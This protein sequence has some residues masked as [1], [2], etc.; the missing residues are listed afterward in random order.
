MGIGSKVVSTQEIQKKL[1]SILIYFDTFCKEHHLP[2]V[3]AGGT[4]L[5]AVRH[6]GFIP[7]DDD[8]DVFMLRKDYEKLSDIW[9]KY[10]DTSRY[11][12]V[13]S[14]EKLNIHHTA[15]EVKD[16]HTTF[17]NRHSIDV[18]MHH[19]L[20]IDII[21][22]DNVAKSILAF[23][24]QV[25][26]ALQYAGFNFQRLPDHKSK[27]VYYLT[28]VALTVIKSPKARYKLW[29]SAEQIIISLG[30]NNSGKV[31]SFGEGLAIAK[32]H[33]PKEWF[34][35]PEFLEFEGHM[36]PV[37]AD[38]DRYLTIS[39]GDY[40]QLPPESEKVA[41]HNAAFIDLENSYEKYRGIEYCIGVGHDK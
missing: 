11:T 22:V 16:N 21:P 41:R 9:N 1:L 31:A 15:G 23:G 29:K 3:L 10:A 34:E 39:Y 12:F 30:K 6:K 28:K 14:N 4:C 38:Y 37:P 40:M 13:R 5:G 8:V 7:W 19:G 25:V 33:F 36:L 27:F 32:Q 24:W 18:D 2:Y 17:I 35:N 20:M 26:M